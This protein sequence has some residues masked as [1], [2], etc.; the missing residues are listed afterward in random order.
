MAEREGFEPS[1][2]L[3]AAHTIS[4]RAPSASSDISPLSVNYLNVSEFLQ[5]TENIEVFW[6]FRIFPENGIM[7][8]WNDGILVFKRILSIY[9]FVVK[10]IITINPI[11]QY[12]LRAVGSAS[13]RPE[14]IIP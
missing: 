4:S 12:P 14:P 11:L 8:Y 2:P 3:L 13:R 6:G 7:E 1:V 10:T 5:L 9:N